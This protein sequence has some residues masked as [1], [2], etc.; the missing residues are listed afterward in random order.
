[1]LIY[2]GICVSI[3]RCFYREECVWFY[4]FTSIEMMKGMVFE[5]TNLLL[6]K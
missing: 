5:R 1:M 2:M 4:K 3:S 6:L